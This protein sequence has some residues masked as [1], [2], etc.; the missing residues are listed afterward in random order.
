MTLVIDT[1]EFA[2]DMLAGIPDWFIDQMPDGQ[3]AALTLARFGQHMI[4]ELQSPHGPKTMATVRKHILARW[5]VLRTIAD[6]HPE[7]FDE[8]MVAYGERWSRD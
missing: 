7:L 8:I 4:G 1:G 5:S 2:P 3:D 6:H